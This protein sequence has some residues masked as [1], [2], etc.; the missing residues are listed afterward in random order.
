[1]ATRIEV[2]N[3]GELLQIGAPRQVYEHPN[4]LYVA[5]RLGTPQI[6]LLPVEA[7]PGL[8]APARAATIGVRT[9]HLLISPPDGADFAARVRRVERLG[10]QTHVHLEFQGRT[11]VTLAR[12]TQSFA[13]DE[14][15]GLRLIDPLCFD[16]EGR[17]VGFVA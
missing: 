14:Q 12:P 6:N 13:H 11:L 2:L 5:A 9:E 4:N 1:M 15:V 10:D 7:L 3:Q 8:H 17:R 16:K